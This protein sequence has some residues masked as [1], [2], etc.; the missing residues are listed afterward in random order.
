[1]PTHDQDRDAS[2]RADYLESGQFL[3]NPGSLRNSIPNQGASWLSTS[4]SSYKLCSHPFLQ[5]SSIDGLVS[6]RDSSRGIPDEVPDTAS[7]ATQEIPLM[8]PLE[9]E[10]LRFVLQ[11]CRN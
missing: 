8:L 6:E 3:S 4:S 2:R 1:M 5:C 9:K 7:A 10:S 11:E